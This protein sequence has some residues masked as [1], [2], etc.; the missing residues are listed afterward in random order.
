MAVT[1]ILQSPAKIYIS[2][3]ATALPNI[4]TVAVGASFG[5]GWTDLGM[6]LSA[7]SMK[8]SNDEAPIDVEQY[9]ASVKL[10]RTKESIV[11]ETMLAEL[12][13]ANLKLAL[14]SANTITTVAAGASVHASD[15]LDFGGESQMPEYQLG[16]EGYV[17]DASNNKMPKRFF[18][19]KVVPAFSG[20]LEFGKKTP[21]GVPIRFTCL[22]DTTKSVGSML[23]KSQLV[24]GWK[25]S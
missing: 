6:T 11:I 8:T 1:D 7:V 9:T 22:A 18:F 12:T 19:Y 24:T 16:F 21:A 10:V 3:V 20:A 25:T 13:A 5:A 14:A 2:A 17:F 4:N 15:T 23:G